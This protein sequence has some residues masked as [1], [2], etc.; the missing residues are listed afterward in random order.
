MG[1]ESN[2]FDFH[3]GTHVQRGAPLR[4]YLIAAVVVLAV[5]ALAYWFV[6]NI[7][8]IAPRYSGKPIKVD[9]DDLWTEFLEDEKAAKRKYTGSFVEVTGICSEAQAVQTPEWARSEFLEGFTVQMGKKE[10]RL[11]SDW[12]IECFIPNRDKTVRNQIDKIQPGGVL[13]IQG[14][15]KGKLGRQICIADCTIMDFHMPK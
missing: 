11:T 1:S 3:K 7:G 10:T 4:G 5:V 8:N 12:K 13:K 14:I 2:P 6:T 15:C 9:E